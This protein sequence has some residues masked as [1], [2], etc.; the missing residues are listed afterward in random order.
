MTR[1]HRLTIRAI[2]HDPRS[3]DI[4]EAAQQLGMPLP[5]APAVADVLFVSGD[6]DADDRRRLGGFLVD[7]LLQ[8]G[9]WDAPLHDGPAFEVTLRPGVTDLAAQTLCRAAGQLGVVVNGAATGRRV[10]FSPETD[11]PLADT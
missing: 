3:A 1:W 4:A 2:D 7:P 11:R 6:L 10:E 5:R 9:T 8:T